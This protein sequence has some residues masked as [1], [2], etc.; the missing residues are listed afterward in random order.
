MACCYLSL[1]YMYTVHL[2]IRPI[3]ESNAVYLNIFRHLYLNIER[4]M[5]EDVTTFVQRHVQ[6]NS[7]T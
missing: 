6:C 2:F 3:P 7:F 1:S 4:I 5:S